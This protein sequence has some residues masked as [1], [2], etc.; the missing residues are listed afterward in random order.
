MI[1]SR[2][3]IAKVIVVVIL[4]I[5]VGA[6]FLLMTEEQKARSA[7]EQVHET[8]GDMIDSGDSPTPEEVH[9]AI[10][11]KPHETRN[12]G[13]HRLVEEYHWKGPM[14]S[15]TVYAYYTTGATQL[16]EAV[17]INHKLEDWEGD[18]K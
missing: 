16:L 1:H 4:A 18:D 7:C 12:P 6:A 15:H 17:S 5:L 11:R 13:R 14:S 3:G 10:G 9:E 8:L 2:F